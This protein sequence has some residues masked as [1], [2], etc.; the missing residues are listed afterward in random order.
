MRWKRILRAVA[1]SVMGAGL[2]LYASD[3]LVFKIRVATNRNPYGSVTVQRFDAVLKK[4][5][6]TQFLFDP[7]QPQ[8]CTNSLFPHDDFAPCWYLNRHR[9]QG[10]SI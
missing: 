10:T 8:T 1:L 9:E 6:K 7:P 2:L 5:G 4:N 3:Y